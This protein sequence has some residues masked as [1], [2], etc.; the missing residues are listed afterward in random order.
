MPS[1]I[2][3]MNPILA[4]AGQIAAF[5]I[6]LF[7]FILVVIA[8]GFNIA[9]AFGLS[10][11][12]DK[13]NIVK[14][15]RPRVDE[16]NQV[17][18]AAITTGVVP[19]TENKVARLVA[20][21]PVQANNVDKKV[22]QATDKVANGV[23]EFQARTQQAKAI[24]KALFKPGLVSR[25]AATEQ[26]EQAEQLN[27]QRTKETRSPLETGQIVESNVVEPPLQQVARSSR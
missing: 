21:V 19:E 13:I 27:G 14:T 6:C 15:L 5:I 3:A 25:R 26:T 17:S 10:W 4:G 18:E 16:V 20:T 7:I 22:E 8:V 1:L 11:L 24:A 9:M 23:I 2:L 12:R